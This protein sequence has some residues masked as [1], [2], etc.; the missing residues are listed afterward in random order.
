[1]DLS[2]KHQ[3]DTQSFTVLRRCCNHFESSNPTLLKKRRSCQDQSPE[4]SRMSFCW[5]ANCGV[6]T[7]SSRL[8]ENIFKLPTLLKATLFWS[9]YFHYKKMLEPKFPSEFQS[10]EF[11]H[12]IWGFGNDTAKKYVLI[13]LFF[14]RLDEWNPV[15]DCIS[16][17]LMMNVN[18][19]ICVLRI[20]L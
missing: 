3:A 8:S 18:L 12:L 2:K 13:F 7:A 5:E 10:D 6:W 20:D 9:A 15:T 4:I 1:M 16:P 14:H 11:L 19:K 17:P